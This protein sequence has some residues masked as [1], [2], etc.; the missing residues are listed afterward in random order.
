MLDGSGLYGNE[1]LW[2]AYGLEGIG[3]MQS[4]AYRGDG[5]MT[6][7][8]FAEILKEMLNQLQEQVD[9]G[10]LSEDD[11]LYL[12]LSDPDNILGSFATAE[13]TSVFA[14]TT[15]GEYLISDLDDSQIEDIARAGGFKDQFGEFISNAEDLNTYL[16]ENPDDF[17]TVLQ[18]LDENVPSD[19]GSPKKESIL[20]QFAS[21]F[22]GLVDGKQQELA[23]ALDRLNKLNEIAA[24]D[25]DEML[26]FL[27]AS[28]DSEEFSDIVDPEV[29]EGWKTE[30][31]EIQTLESDLEKL[32]QDFADFKTENGLDDLTDDELEAALEADPQ[33]KEDYE[34]FE[35]DIKTDQREI[36]NRTD[37]LEDDVRGSLSAITSQ[38]AEEIQRIQ[39][40]LNIITTLASQVMDTLAKA[41]E[42]MAQRIGGN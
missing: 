23:D 20:D 8:E 38:D 22:T 14:D 3:E 9:S 28:L 33:L 4:D 11:P 5:E 42:R 37:D 36:R 21:T 7:D 15:L 29:L 30:R 31:A 2:S 24:S 19:F 26:G 6:L 27:E 32:E 25:I 1:Q 17:D 39:N 18:L 12:A 35:Q 10:K 16:Q 41:L 40:E 13:D 34:K